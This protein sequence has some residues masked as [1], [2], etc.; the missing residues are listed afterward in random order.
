M[1]KNNIIQDSIS[2]ILSKIPKKMSTLKKHN[3]VA[4]C[5][6]Y[7]LSH[8]ICFHLSNIAYLVYNP[9]FHL[10]KGISGIQQ[11]DMKS[12]C[13]DPWHNIDS[14][15]EI[16]HSTEYNKKIKEINFCTLKIENSSEIVNELKNILNKPDICSYTWNIHNNNMGILLYEPNN[17]EYINVDDVESAA[18]IIGFCPIGH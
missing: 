3:T 12:W 4:E 16:V 14:F 17:K 6:L 10:C 13:E 7:E 8:E 1:N 5:I 11:S 2:K 9:D 18:G 15:S